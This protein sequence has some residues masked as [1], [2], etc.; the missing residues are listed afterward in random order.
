[1]MEDQGL[2][3]DMSEKAEE[4]IKREKKKYTTIQTSNK[5]TTK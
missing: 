5:T 4:L 2:V 3:V 1:M